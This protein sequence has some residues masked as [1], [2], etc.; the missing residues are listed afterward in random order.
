MATLSVESEYWHSPSVVKQAAFANHTKFPFSDD[1]L[2]PYLFARLDGEQSGQIAG[3]IAE[4]DGGIPLINYGL[5][6]QET[7]RL[8]ERHEYY[9]PSLVGRLA[10][11]SIAPVVIRSQSQELKLE[12]IFTPEVNKQIDSLQWVEV[13]VILSVLRGKEAL[14]AVDNRKTRT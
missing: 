6:N 13:S 8:D 14:L 12:N 4:E 5:I 1:E 11:T 2:H 10:V 3:V 9:Q 7:Q